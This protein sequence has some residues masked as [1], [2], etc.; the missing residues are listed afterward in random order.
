MKEPSRPNDDDPAPHT[1][2]AADGG[3]GGSQVDGAPGGVV[4]LC[5]RENWFGFGFGLG[6]GRGD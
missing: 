5:G 6:L 1:G 4:W 3:R 2:A